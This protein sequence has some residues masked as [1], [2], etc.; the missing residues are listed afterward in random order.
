ME[1]AMETPEQFMRGYLAEM[2]RLQ[3]QSANAY[4]PVRER[5]FA[6]SYKP[7]EPEKNVQTARNESV[8]SIARVGER[9][10]V[11]TTGYG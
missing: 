1:H 6:P 4:R 3:E 2:A 11:V 10:E 5:Y 8:A 7:Y 9:V